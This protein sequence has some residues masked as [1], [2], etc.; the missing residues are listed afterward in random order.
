[1]IEWN[2]VVMDKWV[3]ENIGLL[4]CKDEVEFFE[5]KWFDYCDMYF[6]MVICFF[7]EVYKCQYLNIML[8]YGCEYFEIVLF[9]I[10]LKCLFYQELLIVNK[11]LLWKVCQFVDCYCCL[12]DYF[13]FIVFFVVV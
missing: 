3:V 6:F 11:M 5:M 12:Y 7:M 8:M 10:G 13:I 9:I 1:M 2:I 4:C